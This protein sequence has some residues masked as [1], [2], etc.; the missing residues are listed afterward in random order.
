M[1]AM[2]CNKTM[3][4]NRGCTDCYPNRYASVAVRRGRNEF[5]TIH[6]AKK[7]EHP[8]RFPGGKLDAG[9]NPRE[10][11]IRELREE[12]GIIPLNLIPVHTETTF[13][14]GAWWTGHFFLCTRWLGDVELKEPEKHDLF[15]W[16]PP[17]ALAVL[18]SHPET[19]VAE[20]ASDPNFGFYRP[21]APVNTTTSTAKG[22]N[23]ACSTD[24]S[25]SEDGV[26]A[27]QDGLETRHAAQVVGGRNAKDKA[28]EFGRYL[29][30]SAE[31][32]M[33]AWEQRAVAEDRE[34]EVD[35]DAFSDA[36]RGLKG[37]I[38]EFRKREKVAL[39]AR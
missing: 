4:H 12:I 1:I 2:N 5:L 3:C 27:T 37:A 33:S 28:V 20:K 19:E 8:W 30:Q 22:R 34:E 18:D 38:Y 16:V 13:V 35:V 24:E 39:E 21:P 29:A 32:F 17:A 6:H 26:M 7:A 31:H 25:R 9:E 15:A 23:L 14:D 36:Y 11:A 10:A